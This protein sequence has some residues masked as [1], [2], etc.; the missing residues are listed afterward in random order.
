M[1]L[2][3]V[4]GDFNPN[5]Y[6]LLVYRINDESVHGI[7]HNNSFA[8]AQQYGNHLGNIMDLNVGAK[9]VSHVVDNLCIACNG[10]LNT[11]SML[12]G[13]AKC[14]LF[15]TYCMPVYGSIHWDLSVYTH[16][17][18]LLSWGNVLERSS[19]SHIRHIQIYCRAYVRIY[20]LKIKSGKELLN[21][22]GMLFTV[23]IH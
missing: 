9:D 16:K 23:P 17:G 13:K 2:G 18:F 4:N 22:T 20:Q 12:S 21:F 14:R 15:K 11:F 5:K 10:L 8:R 7:Y 3:K 6:Q 19:I 1:C